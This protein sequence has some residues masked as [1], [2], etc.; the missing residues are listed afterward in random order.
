MCEDCGWSKCLCPVSCHW[1]PW[2][3][4]GAFTLQQGENKKHEN[5]GRGPRKESGFT[6]NRLAYADMFILKASLRRRLSSQG[7][8]SLWPE[9]LDL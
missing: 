1:Q 7:K 5:V 4:T 6:G 3:S 8:Q 2:R 9:S